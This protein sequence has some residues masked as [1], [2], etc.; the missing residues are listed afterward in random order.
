M[1]LRNGNLILFTAKINYDEIRK[2]NSNNKQ[3]KTKPN[4]TT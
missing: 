3:N 4:Q 2:L 1:L